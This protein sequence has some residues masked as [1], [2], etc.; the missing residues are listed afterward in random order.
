[1]SNFIAHPRIQQDRNFDLARALPG[2]AIVNIETVGVNGNTASFEVTAAENL[3]MFGPELFCC[4]L[5]ST[6]SHLDAY[7]AR[8]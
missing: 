6:R 2:V 5:V 4:T 7:V 3:A 8:G 1:M